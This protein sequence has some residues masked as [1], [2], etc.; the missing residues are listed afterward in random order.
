VLDPHGPAYLAFDLGAE[1]GRAFLGQIVSGSLR[2]QEIHRFPNEPVEDRWDVARLW[3]EMRK[4]LNIAEDTEVLSV[5]VDAWGVDYAL[6]GEN[7]DLLENPRH[8]RDRRNVGAMEEVLRLVPREEIYGTT[9]IQFMPIN[10]INQLFAESRDNPRLLASATRLLMIPDLFHYWMCGNA[11]C[12]LTSA[13]TTQFLNAC[14]RT[15]ADELLRRLELPAGLPAPVVDPGTVLGKLR[16]SAAGSRKGILVIAPASHDTAS[17]VAAVTARDNT[18]FLS[19]GTWSLIGIELDASVLSDEA[20]R[21]NFT[22]EAGV[23]GTTRLLKNV[24]GLWMLQGC[25]RIWSTE[26]RDWSYSDLTQAASE[27][28]PFRH[29]V[30]P[31]DSSFLNPDD[32]LAAIDRCCVR[33]DQLAPRCPAAYTRAILES[34][35]LKYRLVIRD[36]EKLTNRRIEQIRVIG[37][38]SK[39]RLLNQFTADATGRLVLAGPAEAAALGNIGVQMVAM[40]AAGSL[41]E[42]REIIDRSFPAEIFEPRDSADWDRVAERFE[43]YCELTYA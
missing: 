3:L 4:A 22:N 12:E 32:M 16:G 19:S 29:L 35:A 38:G 36:L 25:R 23:C 8:Y 34:L 24:M 1:T 6:L 26:G 42:A 5:G 9:G 17:A 13:S 20:M 31:D 39:N 7:G 11:V 33:S 2:I 43:Q 10:T 30:D 21:L 14:K 40:G 37:G 28:P 41:T 15:W 18:S 27:A